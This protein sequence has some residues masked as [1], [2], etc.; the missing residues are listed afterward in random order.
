MMGNAPISPSL[1]KVGFI[2]SYSDKVMNLSMQWP[3]GDNVF[4]PLQREVRFAL[5]PG[6]ARQAREMEQCVF[7]EDSLDDTEKDGCSLIK[8]IDA[9]CVCPVQ[10]P[11][12]LPLDV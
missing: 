2:L 3:L 8:D 7:P 6:R 12:L 9:L 4:Q 5:C 11:V 1:C 10:L